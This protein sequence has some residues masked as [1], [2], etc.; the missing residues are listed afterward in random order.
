MTSKTEDKKTEIAQFISERLEELDY[1]PEEEETKK[2]T[3]R[4][5]ESA[6]TDLDKIAGKL[7]MTRTACAENLLT[8][9]IREASYIALTDP[10]L[11]ER[12]GIDPAMIA[13]IEDDPQVK[14]VL[15]LARET[16][17]GA[18]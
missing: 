5:V 18:A 11:G 10:A 15:Q 8:A 14:E 2:V 17:E 13:R 3:L 9:A 7:A 16:A 1:I 4:L 12:R 6:V